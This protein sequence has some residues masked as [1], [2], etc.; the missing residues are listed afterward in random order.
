MAQ[1][2]YTLEQAAD[3]L[4][5]TVQEFKKRLRTEWTYIRPLQD[6]STQR[7]KAKDVEELARQI[8]FGSEEEL[9]LVDPSS[10]E[11][12]VPAELKIADDGPKSTKTPSSKTK[13]PSSKKAQTDDDVIPLTEDDLNL[14]DKDVF[15]MADE[16]TPAASTAKKSSKKIK[17]E[18]K[19]KGD[20][21]IRLGQ[22]GKVKAL[23]EE[24][25]DE[26]ELDILPHGGSSSRL[27]GSGKIT[28]PSSGKL[29]SPSSGKLKPTSG[30]LPP[31]PP[32]GGDSS[33]FEL[34]LDADSSDEFELSLANDSSDEISLGDLPAPKSS[35]SKAGMASGI[36][37]G[38]PKDAGLSLEKGAG[39]SSKKI[40]AVKA[41]ADV[42]KSKKLPVVKP[43][44]DSDEVDFELS[45]DQPGSSKKL[46]SS[47]KIADDSDSEFDLSLDDSSDLGANLESSTTS[48][49]AAGEADE[50]KKN[51][52]FET[53]F[54]IPAL[55]DDSAS[56][57]VAI[58]EADTDLESSDFDLAIDESSADISVEE[59]SGSQV[60][61]LDDE[62][63]EPPA[64]AKKKSGKRK[65]A[66]EVD[67][68]EIEEDAVSF[69]DVDLEEGPSASKALKGL[70]SKDVDAE[71]E[72]DEEEAEGRVVV[73][74]GAPWGAL[75]ALCLLPT[76]F[77]MFIAG[78]MSYEMMHSMWGYHQPTQPTAIVVNGVADILDMKPKDDTTK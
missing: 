16:P 10:D 21:D 2:Y 50:E 73:A 15:L 57:A 62:T 26:I 60:V 48:L 13:T 49:P 42:G 12:S 63:D 70:R 51:D 44:D 25:S 78:L 28:S 75:P 53:D 14:G 19:K 1:T 77:L 58:D 4:G 9:Q 76:V 38:K 27:S 3:K 43:T 45:L 41:D 7:F 52:I 23:P 34:S 64:K 59:E 47:K 11:I 56:E 69:D 32:A 74:S 20:S 72:E 37:I 6:G 29:K 33:E 8:G 5:I 35:D 71:E 61:V 18:G 39:R 40:P 31:A 36:N 22:S 17:P 66:V 68:E 24:P 65:K 67:D 46:G 55:D 54:E 30:K